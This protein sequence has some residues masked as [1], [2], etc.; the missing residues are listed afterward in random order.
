MHPKQPTPVARRFFEGLTEYAFQTRFGIA[1]PP[2]TDY[3]SDMLFRFV[4][5]DTV[6]RVRDLT[7]RPLT[8]A[9]A[10]RGLHIVLGR[11]L[12]GSPAQTQRSAE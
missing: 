5:N 2:L 1:D 10:H 11:C 7:G 8:E 4:R 3:L 6:F 12:P 9:P